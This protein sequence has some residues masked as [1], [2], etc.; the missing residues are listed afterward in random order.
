[1]D[2]EARERM[3]QTIAGAFK[4]KSDRAGESDHAIQEASKVSP[5]ST[6][7][8]IALAEELGRLAADLFFEGKL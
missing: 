3:R 6:E 5:S 1:M 7:Q 8:K 2:P 4:R